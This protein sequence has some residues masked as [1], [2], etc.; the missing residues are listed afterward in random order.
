MLVVLAFAALLVGIGVVCPMLIG[1]AATG[2]ESAVGRLERE[3][4]ELAV[5]ASELSAQVSALSA[6]ERV[7]EQAVELGMG[8]ATSVGYLS[9]DSALAAPED[10]TT[11]AG[12]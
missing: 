10:Y 1:S 4:K 8:P 12:R 7:A 3:Q 2:M 5:T 11:L 6:P 9:V